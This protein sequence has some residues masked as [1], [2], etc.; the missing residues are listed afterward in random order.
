MTI[1]GYEW[2]LLITA[3]SLCLSVG[4]AGVVSLLVERL[5]RI[6][7]ARSSRAR[8]APVVFAP[9]VRAHAVQAHAR[10]A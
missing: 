4:I 9:V 2:M 6:R 8:I 10:A 3:V 1:S 5:G 7:A